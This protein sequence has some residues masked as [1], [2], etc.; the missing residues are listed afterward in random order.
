MMAT[1]EALLEIIDLCTQETLYKMST[2]LQPLGSLTQQEVP[3]ILVGCLDTLEEVAV[4][5]L[6]TTLPL[7]AI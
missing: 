1:R 7:M 4:V 5:L 3:N 6:S 2:S